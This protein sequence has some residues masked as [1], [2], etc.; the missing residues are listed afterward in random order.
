MDIK[1]EGAKSV[2][3]MLLQNS[4]EAAVAAQVIVSFLVA[5]IGGWT[6]S[7]Q[8]FVTLMFLDYIAGFLRAARKGNLN[9][10]VGYLG[11]L[12]KTGYFVVLALFFQ[13]G[14]WIGDTTDQAIFVR[15]M[16]VNLFIM[17]ESISILE[18]IR[19]LDDDKS[20]LPHGV[21][22]LLEVVLA[23]DL[24]DRFKDLPNNYR[25]S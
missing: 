9:S 12:K 24:R 7:L 1:F 5:I 16:V 20:Y 25:E 23:E 14:T 18:N 22:E 4:Q 8:V 13:L 6:T 3:K 17:N 11:I 10:T 15:S 21:I 19:H 2:Y